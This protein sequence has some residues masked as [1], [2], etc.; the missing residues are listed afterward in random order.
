M[1]KNA[2]KFLMMVVVA[3]S[4]AVMS[5]CRSNGMDDEMYDDGLIIGDELAMDGDMMGDMPAD[6]QRGLFAPVYFGYD[7]SAVGGSEVSKIEQ[8]AAHLSQGGSGGVI[9]EG[10]C[11]ERGSREYNL[12][13]GERRALAV[14]DYL[15]SL[16]V[17]PSNIQTKSMGSEMP[18]ALGHDEASWSQN[19]R[20]EF[21]IY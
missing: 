7:S 1:M 20:A 6:G 19:R 15:V 8:V 3:G 10:H 17:D 13:L 14:R 4:V 16:G 11:D 9:I 5:G 21:V 12:A 18:V 2:V